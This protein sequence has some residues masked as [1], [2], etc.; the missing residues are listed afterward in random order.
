[1]TRLVLAAAITACALG[2]CAAPATAEPA[3]VLPADQSISVTPVAGLAFTLVR[4]GIKGMAL[5]IV[6]IHQFP[7]FD[8]VIT[9]ES[10]WDVFATNPS[11]GAYGIGQALPPEK[12]RTH[13]ID[14]RFNPMTQIRW[15]YD[16]MVDRYGSPEGAW[17]FWQEHHWY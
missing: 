10:G 12:M 6:P 2:I 1:M 15:T 13:G 5:T 17:A 4:A 7:A 11:S 8:N 9:R 16:Y 3:P 14:W